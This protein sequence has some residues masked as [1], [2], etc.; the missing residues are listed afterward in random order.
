MSKV[1]VESLRK[2]SSE[3][4]T[5]IKEDKV[6]SL[7]RS[8]I[9]L[10]ELSKKI[11]SDLKKIKKHL[12]KKPNLKEEFPEL[13][14]YL[15]SVEG[16]AK[17]YIDLEKLKTNLGAEEVVSFASVSEKGLKDYL[18]KK[19]PGKE[20]FEIDALLSEYKVADGR[21]EPSIKIYKMKE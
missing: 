9:E 21:G 18:T 20:S 10:D 16:K 4:K 6:N 1:I 13:G 7:A 11:D 12:S 17:S 3:I 2:V 15:A 5:N 14:K 19:N 8:Y